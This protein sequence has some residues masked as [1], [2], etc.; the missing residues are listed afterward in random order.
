MTLLTVNPL[1]NPASATPGGGG[2]YKHVTHVC[3]LVFAVF[4]PVI[5]GCEDES[6]GLFEVFRRPL[7]GTRGLP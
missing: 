4:V 5:L 3:Q 7:T 6:M 1:Q 2:V